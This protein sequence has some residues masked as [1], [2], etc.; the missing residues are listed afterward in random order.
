MACKS[1]RLVFSLDPA[2]SLLACSVLKEVT[3][4]RLVQTVQSYLHVM[5]RLGA[6]DIVAGL[7]SLIDAFQNEVFFY[8]DLIRIFVLQNG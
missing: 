6:D 1:L 8:N 4:P 2:V 3:T 5:S 7:E